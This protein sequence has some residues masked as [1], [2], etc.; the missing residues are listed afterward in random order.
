M[1]SA[2]HADFCTGRALPANDAEPSGVAADIDPTGAAPD[3]DPTGAALLTAA[4]APERSPEANAASEPVREAQV[5]AVLCTLTDRLH[6]AETRAAIYDAGMAAM[7][8]GLGCDRAAILLFDNKERMRFAAW[9][10]LSEAYRKAVEGHSPWNRE[11]V[12]AQPILISDVEAGDLDANLKYAVRREGIRG[13]AFFPLVADGQ[14]IGKFMTYYDRPRRFDGEAGPGFTI[15]RQLAFAVSRISASEARARTEDALLRSINAERARASEFE[16]VMESVPTALWVA[17]DPDCAVI[18]GNPA[19]YALFRETP[20]DNIAVSARRERPLPFTA[21]V[22]GKPL[23]VDELPLRRAVKGEHVRDYDIEYRF[24]DGT[25]RHMVANATPLR[26]AQG[27]ITGGVAAFI[28]MTERKRL[29][30]V[31]EHLAA[32]VEFSD[33]AIISKDTDGIIISWNKG[34]ERLFGYTAGEAIG[35][36]ITMVIPEYLLGEEPEILE[37]IRKGERIDHYETVRR[38]KD[39]T[40]VDIALTV[41]PMRNAKGKI[42][43]ASKIARDI[44]EKKKAEAQHSLLMAELNHRVKNTLATVISIARQSFSGREM[45]EARAAFNARIRGLAQS[46]ARLAEADWTSVALQSLFED[47]FAP[48]RQGG[49][50]DIDGPPVAL[51]P[52]CALTLGLAIHELAT[53]AAKYGALSNQKG[54]VEVGWTID[55]N[56][57]SLTISWRERGGPHVVPPS[58]TGFGRLLLE[59]AVPGDLK[60]RIALAFPPEGV[61]FTAVIPSAQYRA[62]VR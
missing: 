1:E 15:A 19:A 34:A 31:Q 16:A 41:S 59:R 51:S 55:P 36:P 5:L 4:P 27:R 56:N 25:V 44:S 21:F 52:K 35:K 38:R 24:D 33:D 12:N 18:T 6:R 58:R 43:A 3:V 32:I 42:V 61:S 11:D 60:A 54:L 57:D 29:G 17:R 62:Q 45:L 14:L 47:E 48:Y 2:R 22:N 7:F 23:A 9:R 37:R 26:D 39:G 28:D 46:H 20:D 10:G 53:N 30:A 50:V 40:L 13:I 49:N 8:A